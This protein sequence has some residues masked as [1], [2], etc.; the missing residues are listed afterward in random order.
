VD[1]AEREAWVDWAVTEDR[2]DRAERVT[3]SWMDEEEDVD[4][5]EDWVERVTLSWMA[6]EEDRAEDWEPEEEAEERPPRRFRRYS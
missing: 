5:V 3:W 6:R 2:V 1:W 4:G